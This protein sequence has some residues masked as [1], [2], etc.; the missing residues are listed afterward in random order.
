ME[1]LKSR[2]QLFYP[3]TV[4]DK[5]CSQ[6]NCF[7]RSILTFRQPKLFYQFAFDSNLSLT[8][9]SRKGLW[10]ATREIKLYSFHLQDILFTWMTESSFIHFFFTNNLSCHLCN[11][12]FIDH[13]ALGTHDPI[14][15]EKGT[16]VN[17]WINSL[18]A[19]RNSGL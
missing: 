10:E 3:R 19:I 13:S 14:C 17:D 15:Q 5:S 7:Y 9:K 12:T 1:L 16:G 2:K 8:G 18:Y 6:S 4:S 11:S